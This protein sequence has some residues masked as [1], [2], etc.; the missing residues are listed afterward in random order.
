[1]KNNPYEEEMEIQSSV[2]EAK[3]LSSSK[4][5]SVRSKHSPMT[6]MEKKVAVPVFFNTCFD[7][8]SL[9]NLIAWFLDQYGQKV[10]VDLVETLKQVGFHQATQAGVSL[11]VDDLLIPPEK[12]EL[13]SQAFVK[14][15]TVIQSL[16]TGNV[17]SVEK[18]QRLIDTWNQTS[19]T[20]RHSAVQNFRVTNPVNPVYMMAFSGARGNISQVRQLVGMRGLMAD[21]QGAILEFPIQSNFREGLT[22]SEYL[23]SCFGARKGLVDTAL[24]TATSGYLTR[25]LVDA[26]QHVVVQISNCQTQKGILLK[27]PKLKQRLIGRVLLT[28]LEVDSS[29]SV[30]KN[31][32]ISPSLAHQLV[33]KYSEIRVRSPLTCETEKSVCQLCY[34]LDLGQG[35]LVSL[36]EAVGIIAAQSIG[37]PGTQL[38]MRTFHT[39]GVGVFSDQA[40]KPLLAPFSGKVEFLDSLPGRFVRTPH[41]N[42]VYLVKHK[43]TNPSQPLLRISNAPKGLYEIFQG[44]VP[45]GSLVWV[46]Q[47]EYVEP[48]QL[49]IQASRLETTAQ[50]MPESSHP[51]VSPISG[52]VVFERMPVRFIKKTKQSKLHKKQLKEDDE[53]KPIIPVLFRLGKF[54]VFSSSLQSETRISEAFFRKGDFVSAET[55]LQQ[56]NL[57]LP[58]AGQLRRVGSATVLGYT[59]LQLQFTKLSYSQQGYFLQPIPQGVHKYS[60]L[61]EKSTVVFYTKNQNQLRLTWY[62]S[63]QPG[64]L[65]SWGYLFFLSRER[66]ESSQLKTTSFKIQSKGTPNVSSFGKEEFQLKSLNTDSLPTFEPKTAHRNFNNSDF[67]WAASTVFHLT[68]FTQKELN[69]ARLQPN[70]FTKSVFFLPKTGI[71]VSNSPFFQKGFFS[72]QSFRTPC[73]A[74]GGQLHFQFKQNSLATSAV[75]PNQNVQ[76]KWVKQAK[77]SQNL[78]K[79]PFSK[80][81]LPYSS[82]LSKRK[83]NFGTTTFFGTKSKD[84]TLNSIKIQS[85]KLLEARTQSLDSCFSFIENGLEKSQSLVKSLEPLKIIRQKTS[86]FFVPKRVFFSSQKLESILRQK[87]STLQILLEPGKVFET[88]QFPNSFVSVGLVDTQKMCILKPK[89]TKNSFT[90]FNQLPSFYEETDIVNSR[91]FLRQ[92]FQNDDLKPKTPVYQF[93]KRNLGDSNVHGSDFCFYQK[94]KNDLV[95]SLKAKQQFGFLLGFQ[96]LDYCLSPETKFLK[97]QWFQLSNPLPTSAVIKSPL[98]AKQQKTRFQEKTKGT[99]EFQSLFP[100]K[101]GWFSACQKLKIKINF[102]LTPSLSSDSTTACSL[103]ISDTFSTKLS[104]VHRLSEKKRDF[105]RQDIPRFQ[106]FFYQKIHLETFQNSLVQSFQNGWLL[107]DYHFTEAFR[108][109]NQIGEFRTIQRKERNSQT[110]L[111]IVQIENLQSFTLPIAEVKRESFKKQTVKNFDTHSPSNSQNDLRH[112]T[113][114]KGKTSLFLTSSKKVK[115]PSRDMIL[116]GT[117]VRWGHEILSGWALPES[118]RILKRTQNSV[119]LRK[120][121][122]LL[123][124]VRGLVHTQNFD[125][126]EKNELLVT[127]RSR[128]LQTEDIVQGIP[129]IEQLFEARETRAGEIIPNNMHMLLG[130]FFEKTFHLFPLPEAIEISLGYIQNFLVQTIRDA[131]STQGVEIAEKHIEIVVRQMTARVRILESGQTGLLPGEFIQRHLIEKVNQ[132]LLQEGALPATYEPAILGI[133]KSVLQSESFL[134]AA[135]FQ[136]VSRVLVRSALAKKT[137]FLRGLHENLL[138]GQVIPAGTGTISFQHT[139]DEKNPSLMKLHDSEEQVDKPS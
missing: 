50:E 35:K 70:F 126:V 48:G 15:Q 59:P 112:F 98:F 84:K 47:G 80:F 76:I 85:S 82:S 89:N 119:L 28:D 23:I 49:L 8:T 91:N 24:R 43:T 72:I 60:F 131:Y 42:I 22:V 97:E 114:E 18:S 40:M 110:C 105:S 41:G 99:L 20:L 1:M 34:G 106:L 31:T 124:S 16:E 46:K 118:G 109:S 87:Q 53:I 62:P 88:F 130:R 117:D 32:L 39:G 56:Y 58:S 135:S 51:V 37:E 17:T 57:H 2:E 6:A 13:L 134:L 45:A 132:K 93:R 125:L 138:V 102:N 38:T 83:A 3:K 54:W 66:S 61:K 14:K 71:F 74:I 116:V 139:N 26:V 30:K 115:F 100:E 64:S 104:L 55:P 9:K 133:T 75:F 21:P 67:L 86:W 25:R 111:S 33:A 107:P 11:G 136:Q 73:Q 121:I 52:E 78:S 36:G 81:S 7:K 12:G 122:P 65:N 96:K 137:D 95:F 4:K 63:L 90:K 113:N 92:P 27:G 77:F 29:S 68:S 69:R 120:G 103:N 19:E 101:T 123:A 94:Q 128:R 10:T 108:K 44:D 79:N 127:L 5:Q 129:K